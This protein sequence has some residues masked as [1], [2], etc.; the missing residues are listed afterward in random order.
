MFSLSLAVLALV[1]TG[2]F[3]N[4]RVVERTDPPTTLPSVGAFQ[5]QGC[6]VDTESGTLSFELM[7]SPKMTPATC[8]NLCDASGFILAGLTGGTQCWCG[9]IIKGGGTPASASA[10]ANACG[11]NSTISCGGN[12]GQRMLIYEKTPIVQ[13]KVVQNFSGFNSMGCF[14]DGQQTRALHHDGGG[15]DGQTVNDCINTCAAAGLSL[16]GVESGLQCFCGNAILNN[17]GPIDASKCNIAC[18][19]DPTQMCGGLDAFNLYRVGNFAFTSGPATIPQT[20]SNWKFLACTQ[21]TSS[22][23]REIPT[24]MNIPIEMMTVDACTSACAA[25]NFT[26]AGLQFGQECRCGNVVLP[27]GRV[28]DNTA[29]SMA[30][31]ADADQFCGGPGVNQV[32]FIPSATFAKSS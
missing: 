6:F 3:A 19:G 15:S 32:Y 21:E 22:G 9:N 17:H 11:G 24:S 1:S 20:S 5:S 16:A 27:P 29:C 8:T 18:A 4:P 25:A 7:D 28:M 26:V 14:S 23:P 30:C 10:C 13:P 31:N 2:A 12:R